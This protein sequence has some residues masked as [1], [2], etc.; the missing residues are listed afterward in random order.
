M[1]EDRLTRA[2]LRVGSGRGFVVEHLGRLGRRPRRIVITAA[3]CIEQETRA[4]GEQGLPP[5]HPG[6]YL[7][8]G[9]Y[10]DL[11]G[12]LGDARAV[13][14]ECLFADP[15]ADIAELGQPD[16]QELSDQAG[17]FDELV[18]DMTALAVA[19]APAQGFEIV[20]RG[21]VMLDGALIEPDE[22]KVPTPG[23]GAARVL[24]LDGRWLDG[25]VKRRSGWLAFEPEKHIASGMSG[26]PIINMAGEAIGVCS[27]E[28][29]NPVIVECLSARLVRAIKSNRVVP[30]RLGGGERWVTF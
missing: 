13:W 5:C 20:R 12:P 3:H 28:S 1:S 22:I 14:A 8:E 19:D 4:D 21:A 18:E 2:V 6:R 25:R 24:A 17:A 15:I 30:D 11:L 7:A 16:N 27:T 9:T 29:F 10:R 23:E 26:S